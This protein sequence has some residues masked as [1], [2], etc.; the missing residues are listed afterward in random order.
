MTAL[1][2]QFDIKSYRREFACPGCKSNNI[3]ELG[4]R[5]DGTWNLECLDCGSEFEAEEEEEQI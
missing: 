3:D 1:V 5:A 2:N 4:T